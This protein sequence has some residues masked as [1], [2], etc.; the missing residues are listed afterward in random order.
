MDETPEQSLATRIKEQIK[1]KMTAAK[2]KPVKRVAVKEPA[3]E[4][5]SKK[6]KE[7]PKRDSAAQM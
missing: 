1:V 6:A 7:T 4:P 5:A 3:D 2:H